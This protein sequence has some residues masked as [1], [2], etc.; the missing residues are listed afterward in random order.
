MARSPARKKA[1]KH[2]LDSL[3]QAIG[4]VT[5]TWAFLDS[6]VDDCLEEIHEKWG[7]KTVNNEIP[8]ISMERKI[9][10]LR[11][12]HGQVKNMSTIF[13]GLL[14]T[15]DALEA[16]VE[17]RHRIIH[18]ISVNLLEFQNTG[19]V[20]F[21]RDRVRRK[22]GNPE[23]VTFTFK[24]LKEFRDWAFRLT[25]FFGALTEILMGD[26]MAEDESHKSFGTIFREIGGFLPLLKRHRRRRKKRR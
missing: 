20:S 6:I 25:I 7:G 23:S 2:T 21:Y 4:E 13:P 16:A 10:Y 18:G 22:G 15:V 1:P 3:F 24:G 26:T 19:K 8:H 11:R 12:W 17:Q 9:T 14:N 5:V